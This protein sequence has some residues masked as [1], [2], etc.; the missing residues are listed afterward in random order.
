MP[1]KHPYRDFNFLVEI[2]GVSSAQFAEVT[3]PDAEITVVEYR[4]GGDKTSV[5]RKLP[6]RVRYGN[7]VL[8]RGV[9]GDLALY[10]WFRAIATGDFQPRNVS[11]VLLDAERQPVIRWNVSQAWPTKYDV[12][13]FKGKSNEVVIEMLELTHEGIQVEAVG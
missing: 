8:K 12:S 1:D 2:E 13:D 3:V 5:T 4:E 6:G 11:I 9:S 10:D 7:V